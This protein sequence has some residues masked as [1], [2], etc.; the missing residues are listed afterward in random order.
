MEQAVVLGWILNALMGIIMWFMKSTLTD[1]KQQIRDNQHEL[2]IV[3]DTYFKRID[4]LDFKEEL[5]DRLSRDHEAILRQL[6]RTK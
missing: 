6:E 3:K 1:L 5:F 4:F 2:S